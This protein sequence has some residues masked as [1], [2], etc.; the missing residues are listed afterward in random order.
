MKNNR[1]NTLRA[2]AYTLIKKIPYQRI[3]DSPTLKYYTN[4]KSYEN[5]KIVRGEAPSIEVTDKVKHADIVISGKKVSVKKIIGIIVRSIDS[6]PLILP[7]ESKIHAIHFASL[8]N[9][10]EIVITKEYSNTM[11]LRIIIENAINDDVFESNHIRI[12]VEKKVNLDLILIERSVSR[13]SSYN[14]GIEL[15]VKEKASVRILHISRL[16]PKTP[17]FSHLRI[18]AYNHSKVEISSVIQGSLMERD[19]FDLILKGDNVNANFILAVIGKGKEIIDIIVDNNVHGAN[20]HLNFRAIALAKDQSQISIRPTGRIGSKSVNAYVDISAHMYNIGS[21]SKAIA[22]PILEINTNK[23]Q[24]AKHA[25]TI[26]DISDDTLFYISTRGL[27]KS[28]IE[29]LLSQELYEEIV[30]NL[31]E[32]MKNAINIIRQ[33]F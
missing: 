8:L 16:Y 11:P 29:Y 17:A 27:S 19:Q 26:T 21:S 18:F 3:K 32:G 5:Y 23:I 28:D 9:A 14:S 2:Y 31:P 12:V 20:N 6:E 30:N 10:V 1:L 13:R 25:I 4:W 24:T 7:N 15:L 22:V 33:S